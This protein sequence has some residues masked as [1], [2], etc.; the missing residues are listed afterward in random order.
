MARRSSSERS[1]SSMPR[2]SRTRGRQAPAISCAT[3]RHAL[4]DQPFGHVGGQRA[5]RPGRARAAAACRGQRREQPGHRGQHEMQRVDG[6]ENRLLVLL[7][8]PVVGQ[9]QPLEGR[10]Q[11]GEV[12]DAPARLARVSSATSG[13]FFCGMIDFPVAYASSSVT[14][15][16]SFVA[17]STISSAMRDRSTASIAATNAELGDHVALEAVA[18][19]EFSPGRSKPSS[20][21]TGGGVQ[22]ERRTGQCARAVGAPRRGAAVPVAEPV[23]VLARQRPR[24]RGPAGGA[25]AGPAAR[26][27]GGCVPAWRTPRWARACCRSPGPPSSPP[28]HAVGEWLPSP[29]CSRRYMRTSVAP[30]LVVAR[31]PGAQPAAE[32]GADPFDQAS[33]QGGVDVL[34]G[35]ERRPD[36]PSTTSASSPVPEPPCHRCRPQLVVGEQ[37][38]AQ[39]RTRACARDPAMLCRARRQSKCPLESDRAASA[40]DGPPANRPPQRLTWLACRPMPARRIPFVPPISLP[41]SIGPVSPP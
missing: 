11:P 23:D 30:D 18:S 22:A 28:K 26:A 14:K 17:Q 6:V 37:S 12:A 36:D 32:L 34:V 7:Q 29:A 27:A 21:A 3:R 41:T 15:E 40:S 38:R 5:T 9:R 2:R 25:R 16:N 35:R 10:E 1:A 24:R 8:I 13:F 19:I 4:P 31:A 39:C 20:A 33:F